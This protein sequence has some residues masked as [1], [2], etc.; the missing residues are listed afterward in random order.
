MYGQPAHCEHEH[1]DHY[2]VRDASFIAHALRRATSAWRGAVEESSKQTAV[3]DADGRE[4]KDVAEREETSVE[5]P[6]LS[7]T[8]HVDVIVETGRPDLADELVRDVLVIVQHRHVQSHYNCPEHGND[9]VGVAFGAVR[10]RTDGVND[11]EVAIDGH[12]DESV[13]APVGRYVQRVLVDLTE[14]VPERP[15]RCCVR[16]R[17]ERDA[18]DDE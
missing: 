4:R 7:R 17:R 11:G 8:V 6:T 10:H 13:D 1:Y 12:Q 14:D 2:H 15:Y 3:Q 5:D 18:H 16:H 9:D